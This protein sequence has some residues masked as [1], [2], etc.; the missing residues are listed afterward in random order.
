MVGARA[1][2]VLSSRIL[3]GVATDLT[4]DDGDDGRLAFV[5]ADRVQYAFDEFFE[6]LFVQRPRLFLYIACVLHRLQQR[7]LHSVLLL[8]Q[9]WVNDVVYVDVG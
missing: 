2:A 5:I 3:T 4:R 1:Y 6:I 8:H 9:Y 7:E